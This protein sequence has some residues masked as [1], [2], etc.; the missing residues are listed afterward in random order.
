MKPENKIITR[1]VMPYY[2][3]A[4]LFFSV[5]IGS[6]ILM[7]KTIQENKTYAQNNPDA[8]QEDPVDLLPLFL[9]ITCVVL[10]VYSFTIIPGQSRRKAREITYEY[11]K[12]VMAKHPELRQYIR[13]LHNDKMLEMLSAVVCNGLSTQEQKRIVSFARQFNKIEAHSEVERK[14]CICDIEE[15][16]LDVVKQ[17]AENNPEYI[18]N[19]KI[20]L[21]NIHNAYML[22]LAQKAR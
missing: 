5:A 8:R 16:I 21:A 7:H 12:T 2:I 3:G 15:Q 9:L 1:Y 14:Q 4:T 19:I 18:G 22:N 10:G 17:H 13:V 20:A 11:V 6:G